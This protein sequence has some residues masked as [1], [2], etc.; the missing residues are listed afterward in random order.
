M[1]NR[2]GF[3]WPQKTNSTG[4]GKVGRGGDEDLG[5]EEDDYFDREERSSLGAGRGR[6]DGGRIADDGIDYEAEEDDDRFPPKKRLKESSGDKSQQR[7]KSAE[8]EEEIDP[9]DAFM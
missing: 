5:E 3:R 8:E 1:F 6:V 9:L 2:G 4:N 7:T